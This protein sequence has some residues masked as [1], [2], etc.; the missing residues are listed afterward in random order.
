MCTVTCKISSFIINII[1]IIIII[2]LLLSYIMFEFG[3][4]MCNLLDVGGGKE[5]HNVM[6]Q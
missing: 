6:P 5:S 2:S 1:I 4:V 3:N